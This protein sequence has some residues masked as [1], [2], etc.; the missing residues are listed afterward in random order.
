MIAETEE[1]NA[2][3]K[4]FIMRP[5]LWASL[6]N[7]G[8]T[9]SRPTTRPART[10]STSGATVRDTLDVA[11]LKV[12]NLNGYPVYKSTQISKSRTRGG[13]D[14][15]QHVHPG[16]R[17]QRLPDRHVGAIE[18]AVSTQGD[19]PFVADQTWLR[20][21]TYYDGAPRHEASFVLCDNLLTSF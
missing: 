9:P 17:L 21:V 14:D 7:R 18:F 6:V 10:C 15:Q 1:Q 3:F 19:T 8:P 5:L 16:R 20:G 4:A 12:G 2:T 11:R 13:G